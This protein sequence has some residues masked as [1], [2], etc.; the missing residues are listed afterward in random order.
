MGRKLSLSTCQQQQPLYGHAV[1]ALPRLA[2][3]RFEAVGLID[4]DRGPGE[5]IPPA[6]VIHKQRGIL[7]NGLVA[8]QQHVELVALG[9]LLAIA[10]KAKLVVANQLPVKGCASIQHHILQE[11]TGLIRCWHMAC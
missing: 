10:Y 8:G 6:F 4:D 9:A 11:H 1:N 5:A 7:S 2:C 3:G